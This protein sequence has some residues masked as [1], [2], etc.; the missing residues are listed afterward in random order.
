MKR[1]K[2]ILYIIDGNDLD[3]SVADKVANLAR[4]NEASVTVTRVQEES[5][6]Y[7]IAHLLTDQLEDANK[8]NQAQLQE[9]IDRVIAH[10]RW[11]GIQVSGLLLSGIG[12]ISVIQEVIRSSHDL[13]ILGDPIEDGV[14]QLAM[15][16]IRKCPCPVWVIR[17]THT[18]DFRRVLATVDTGAASEEAHALNRKIIELAH[19]LAQ[20]ENGEAHYLTAWRLEY[21][22]MLRGPRMKVS[23]EEMFELKKQLRIER[24]TGMQQLFNSINIE[25]DPEQVHIVE[26]DA[27]AVIDRLLGSLEIDV[28]IMGSVARSGIP[29]LLIGNMAEKVLNNLNCTVLTV[30]P[31]GFVSPVTT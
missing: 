25:P 14:D 9:D 28:L 31:D 7:Q 3:T 10:E 1:F 29:G 8:I 11:R 4:L 30:K 23:P 27:T 2:N 5:Y 26:G 15:R 18:G 22:M 6:F 19:S 16:L 21:E 24:E 20:R 17:N 12:F 13:V